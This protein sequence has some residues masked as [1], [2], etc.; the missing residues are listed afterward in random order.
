MTEFF[1]LGLVLRDTEKQERVLEAW[2]E[3]GASGITALDCE[4]ESL[5]RHAFQRDDTPLFPS[6]S[7]L[8]GSNNTDQKFLFTIVKGN[9]AL[10]QII[11]VTQRE[12]GDLSQPGHG[13]LFAW[14]LALV[15]G[16]K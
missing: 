10:Q 3:A 1:F 7:S 2:A 14:P 13:I 16:V 12:T 6:L 5:D 15:I 9:A 8:L 11:E 4:G